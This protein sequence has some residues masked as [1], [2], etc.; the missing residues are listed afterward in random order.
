MDII[1]R[2]GRGRAAK[3]ESWPAME[4]FEP[5]IL[6]FKL[7]NL[8]R[9]TTDGH[10]FEH[11]K[12]GWLSRPIVSVDEITKIDETISSL[13]KI[14]CMVPGCSL[15]FLSDRSEELD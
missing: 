11:C 1:S 14:K 3:Y 6:K 7:Q 4:G 5:E 2:N 8:L 15:E 12:P 13:G 9:L 10:W